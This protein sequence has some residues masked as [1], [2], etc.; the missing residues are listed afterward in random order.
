MDLK[1]LRTAFELAQMGAGFTSPNP[2]VG[3]VLTKNGKIIGQGYHHYAGGDHAEVVAIKSVKNKKLLHGSTLYVT[4]EPCCHY[5]KTSPCIEAIVKAGIKQIIVGM[6]DPSLKVNGRGIKYLRKKR[7]KVEVINSHS[8]LALKIRGL[9]QSWIKFE[10]YNLPYVVLKAAISLDGKIATRSGNSK[11]ITNKKSRLDARQERSLC[12]A[13]LV[14]AGTIKEDN[15]KLAPQAKFKNKKLLRVIIDID[16]STSPK[17]KVYRDGNVVVLTTKLASQSRINKFSKFRINLKIFKTNIE[18]EI[19]KI[20]KYLA[21]LNVQKLFVEGG[22]G[23]HGTFYDATLKKHH[24]I[25]EVIFY[26]APKIIGGYQS[27]SAVGGHG[28]GKIEQAIQFSNPQIAQL[29]DDFK[30]TNFLNNY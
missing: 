26:F 21:S 24:L 23:V 30:I 3:A 1:F 27:K 10:K 6:K 19:E 14:G 18:I 28:V 13:V 9:N 5:G 2:A 29:G 17:A 11:W 22:S 8:K 12:D 25:D 15:P 4:L 7:I 16:L 20:L